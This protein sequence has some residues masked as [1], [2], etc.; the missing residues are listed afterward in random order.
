MKWFGFRCGMVALS[1]VATS[2]VARGGTARRP[3]VVLILADDMG[4]TDAGCFGSDFYQTP[5]IDRLAAEGV[6]FTDS[7]A[8]CHVCSPTRASIMTGKYPARLHLT[9]YIPG[10]RD[11]LLKSPPWTKFLPLK[12]VTIAERLASKGYVCGHFG[13]WHLNKD[14]NYRPGRP[15]DPG[16]QGFDTVLTTVKPRRD[17]APKDAHHVRQ[18]T[19]AA[20]AFMQQNRERPFFCYVSH[21][22]LHRPVI[23]S[24]KLVERYQQH[25]RHGSSDDNPIYAAMVDELDRSV[26][27]IMSTLARLGIVDETLLIFT[28]DNGGFLGDAKDH[29]TSNAPL[30]GGKGT[31]YEGGVRVPTIIR[32]PPATKPGTVCHEPIISNDFFATLDEVSQASGDEPAKKT[33]D[34]VSL[35]PLLRN[36][37]SRL[38]RDALFWH[39][40]HYHAQ[41][42]TPHG[43]IR[44]GNW[45]LIEFY[46]D[47]HVELYDLSHDVGEQHDLARQMPEK[48]ASLRQRLHQW[49]EE[50]G[51][52][53]PLRRD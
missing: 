31:N 12:E 27:R 47:M 22:T 38:G 4:W 15:G 17:A 28:S 25:I 18:I 9:S 42:A 52:Q 1:L 30:R 6:K 44:L 53:M 36:P 46:E 40:P 24:P 29:G 3:N 14:K 11:G 34:G 13:K 8:A 23:G 7:Y 49:R 10:Y 26:G 51:A 16:S 48:A 32:W 2:A 45:K 50:V 41:G 35:L 19:D 37:A 5:H 20:I 43:A 21:N 33:W 39:F